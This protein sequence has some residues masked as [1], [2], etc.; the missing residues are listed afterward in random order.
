VAL[1]DSSTQA[2]SVSL[3]PGCKYLAAW[4]AVDVCTMRLNVLLLRS[5][6]GIE[7]FAARGWA[8]EQVLLQRYDICNTT[9]QDILAR[10]LVQHVQTTIACRGPHMKHS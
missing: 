1:C 4:V 7:A 10:F 2:G 5:L 3:W 9:V 6:C 8:C